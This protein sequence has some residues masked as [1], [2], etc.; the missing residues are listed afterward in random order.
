MQNGGAIRVL[1]LLDYLNI[2]GTKSYVKGLADYFIPLGIHV[3]V[4]GKDGSYSKV[5]ERAGCT[6][7]SV[8]FSGNAKGIKAKLIDIITREKI[9]IIHAHSPRA[10]AS[11]AEIAPMLGIPLVGTFHGT[12]YNKKKMLKIAEASSAII[13]VSPAV[14]AY[15]K[16]L[17]VQ[18]LYIPLTINLEE[19]RFLKKT[20]IRRQLGIQDNASVVLYAA[21]QEGKK[22]AI[23]LDVML[24][25]RMLRM[26]EGFGR[27]QCVIAGDGRR[28]PAV[29]RKAKEYNAENGKAYIH[30][31][32]GHYDMPALFSSSTVVIGT[33]L[34]ALEAMACEKPLIAAGI[35]GFI[36]V[37]DQNNFEMSWNNG[38]G[39]HQ[40]DRLPPL[41]PERLAA[42]LKGVL[43]SQKKRK[44]LGK[45]GWQIVKSHFDRTVNNRIIELYESLIQ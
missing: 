18:S 37:V 34:S 3:V 40:F 16:K 26:T 35:Q 36:G 41:H 38:F 24:A 27:L 6:V 44:K 17:G 21:R 39:D 5:L 20:I 12:Y 29:K 28:L 2:S 11:A 42:S 45:E 25:C 9:T 7:Y 31:I 15:W 32:G 4:A 23:S 43:S 30:V 19:F 8:D 13:S 33:G 14:K 1:M 10:G 22:A